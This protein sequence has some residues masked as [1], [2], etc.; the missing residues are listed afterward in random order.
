MRATPAAHLLADFVD[1]NQQLA[2]FVQLTEKRGGILCLWGPGGIGK[3]TLVS[4]LTEEC[5][6]RHMQWVHVEW[7]D[8][9][10][11]GYLD[12][13]RRVRDETQKEL[14]FSF[15]DVV[16][17]Y[18]VPQYRLKIEAACSPIGNVKVEIGDVSN[19]EVEIQVGHKIVV[20]DLMLQA[21]RPDQG[22]SE[23]TVM[24]E[25]T[26]AFFR[27]L[28]E[29]IRKAKLV[30]FCDAMEKADSRMTAWL[31]GEL[32]TRI[33]DGELTNLLVVLAARE[34]LP[35]DPSFAQFAVEHQLQG[36]DTCHVLEYLEKKGVSDGDLLAE[37]LAT[38]YNGN[39]LRIASSVNAF[40]RG[41]VGMSGRA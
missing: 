37:F 30:I 16:N 23:N 6:L 19:S 2:D 15:N 27:C 32:L 12:F 38:E 36:L 17:F 39:P 40:L 8:S 4:R 26:N 5:N 7:R 35:I 14:F 13:M 9:R 29:C 22:V 21:Q 28:A 33:R 31:C 25:V 18:T 3:S 20:R 41:R 11:Y 1:R 24:I 10:L 34:P